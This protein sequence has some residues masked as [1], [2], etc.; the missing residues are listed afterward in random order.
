MGVFWWIP[1][2][3]P[4]IGVLILL[5][6]PG[7]W[8]WPVFRWEG[9]E[10]DSE[11]ARNWAKF[12][13]FLISNILACI[14]FAWLSW[15]GAV[16]KM[17]FNEVWNYKVTGIRHEMQWTEEVTYT[18]T[19]DDGDTTDSE[20]NVT[21]HS[22]TETRHR[23]DTYG[24]YWHSID[25]YGDVSGIDQSEYDYWKAVWNTERQT[26]M[27]EGSSAG[28]DQKID[29]PIFE[30]YWP[31]T[32]E[33]IWPTCEINSYVNKIRVSHSVLQWGKPTPEQLAKYPR[34]VDQG[35]TMPILN[36]GGVPVT[37]D[38]ALYLR[39]VNAFFGVEKQ[40]HTMLVLFG[41]EAD[42]SVVQD[43]MM[44]WSGPNK[45]E[46]ITFISLDGSKVRWVEVQSW[47]DNTKL[48]GVMADEIMGQPFSIRRYG[49]LLLKHVPKLWHRKH[50]TPIN[51]YLKVDIH[52]GWI[53]LAVFLSIIAGV[54]SYFVI[55]NLCVSKAEY[56]RYR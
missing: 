6:C 14:L 45:N 29:G 30:C 15:A 25:E 39:R 10:S 9:A 13:L 42:R 51:A 32:F 44:A 22:H 26:G 8:A 46:L 53:I 40:I 43:I 34:P 11:I 7:K 49:D 48:H 50:F 12:G 56:W 2:L 35:N 21:H 33:T 18:V 41:K 47:M 52:P 54:V 5:V 17:K 19:V 24:P 28:W 3:I 16:Q 27:H 31:K 55:E 36:Y 37:A 23:T 4:I 1:A 38:E 20:G